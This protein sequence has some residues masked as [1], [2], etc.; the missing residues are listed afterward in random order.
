ACGAPTPFCRGGRC[1]VCVT[2]S[3]CPVGQVCRSSGAATS[4]V[5]GCADDSRCA[6]GQ[7]CCD[8]ACTDTTKDP[9]HCG[10]CGVTCTTAHGNAG[11]VRGQ[12][13]TGAGDPPW[14]DCTHDSADGCEATLHHDVNNCSA[15]GARCSLDNAIPG[16]GID[17]CYV[18]AC[19]YGWDDCNLTSKDG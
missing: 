4:C 1:V 9:T 18:A 19:Q 11:W 10:G 8:G 16:C 13:V 14:Q 2:D 12:R 5:T 3:D 17:G 15:C 6:M 7:Q